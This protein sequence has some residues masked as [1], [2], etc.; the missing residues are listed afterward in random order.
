MNRKEFI[1]LLRQMGTNEVLLEMPG[2]VEPI[3][4]K[5]KDKTESEIRNTKSLLVLKS[6]NISFEDV[7]YFLTGDGEHA[8]IVKGDREIETNKYGIQTSLN[9][10]DGSTFY[11]Y[12]TR[13]NGIIECVSQN[14]NSFSRKCF[15][16]NGNCMIEEACG[17]RVNASLFGK[18]E[19]NGE[20][21]D[22]VRLDKRSIVSEFNKNARRVMR[23]YPKTLNFYRKL[24]EQIIYN[25]NLQ[26]NPLNKMQRTIERLKAEN[27]ALRA[28]N[29]KLMKRLHAATKFIEGVKKNPASRFFL[30]KEINDVD[31]SASLYR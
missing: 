16:D 3:Y 25:I 4:L 22:R 9:S 20:D 15:L 29:E 17:E 28:R 24:Q 10:G 11:S 23:D 26:N 12:M 27:D 13:K 31:V 19:R 2:I 7:D 21:I 5:C 1:S 6:G 14:H 18:A 8:K 30:K